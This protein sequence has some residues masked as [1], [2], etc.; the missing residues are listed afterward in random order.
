MSND[1][2]IKSFLTY[3][4]VVEVLIGIAL[5]VV[6]S[7]AAL[8]LFEEALSGSLATVLAMVA[9]AAIFSLALF[10]WFARVQPAAF[11]AVKVLLFY[12]VV[13]SFVLLYGAL[14]LGFKGVVLWLAIIFHFYQTI[15]SIILLK[16]MKKIVET[17]S[18]DI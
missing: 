9:G 17:K 18:T 10:C 14:G 6:P 5:M 2:M 1:F 7:S 16:G 12:N 13:L 11:I 15:V 8:L 4:A 3:T